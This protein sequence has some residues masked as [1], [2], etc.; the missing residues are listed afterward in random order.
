MRRLKR[1][2][3][4]QL[5]RKRRQIVRLPPPQH[6]DWKK[7]GAGTGESNGHRSP[8]A[9]VDYDLLMDAQWKQI[10]GLAFLSAGTCT[11]LTG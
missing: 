6:D 10:P 1:D 3:M 9:C 5:P 8:D 7:A 11:A 2:V 4:S